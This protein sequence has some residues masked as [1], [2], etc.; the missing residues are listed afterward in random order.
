MDFAARR[1][2]MLFEIAA[3]VVFANKNNGVCQFAQLYLS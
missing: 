2:S 3:S 1:H